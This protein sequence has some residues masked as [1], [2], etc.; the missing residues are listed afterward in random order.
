MKDVWTKLTQ[1]FEA[2]MTMLIV[3]LRKQISN[4]KCGEDKD[5]CAN[6]NKIAELREQLA[7]MGVSLTDEEYS[8]TLLG[9][10]P[11][12]YQSNLTAI[13]T[14]NASNQ[15]P[16][17]PE[18]IVKLITDEYERRLLSDLPKAKSKGFLNVLSCQNY[19][20]EHMFLWPKE[21]GNARR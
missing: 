7:L 1:M 17:T 18:M 15:T 3:D 4:Q 20:F 9:S 11:C 21:S 12:S 14:Y 2:R 5:V 19:L 8:M 13:T 10:L 16:F 6:F